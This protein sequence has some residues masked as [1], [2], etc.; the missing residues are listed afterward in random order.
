MRHPYANT[1]ALALS[2]LLA[3]STGMA[4]AALKPGDAAPA[5]TTQGAQAGKAF[6]FDISAALKKGPVVL[7]FFP[8]AFT[9]GCTLEAHA[10]AEAGAALH[11]LAGAIPRLLG[12][13]LGGMQVA[14]IEMARQLLTDPTLVAASERLQVAIGAILFTPLLLYVVLA[15][16]WSVLFEQ[17]IQPGHC[18]GLCGQ[19]DMLDCA[20]LAQG[21]KR[22]QCVR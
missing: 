14:P 16:P 17:A 8:K 21:E 5:F 1:K 2:A 12:D 7:Y 15:L 18:T 6:T 13:A 4:H 3:C 20:V 9:Q 11:V 19:Q 22:L 10:F